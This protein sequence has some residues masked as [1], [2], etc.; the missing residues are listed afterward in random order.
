MLQPQRLWKMNRTP[1][2]PATHRPLEV[3]QCHWSVVRRRTRRNEAKHALYHEFLLDVYLSAGAA[4]RTEAA[5]NLIQQQQDGHDGINTPGDTQM[6]KAAE[7]LAKVSPLLRVWRLSVADFCDIVDEVETVVS[8][9][10]S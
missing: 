8:E 10:L 2:E 9:W 3:T 4:F 6:R 5:T 7:Y 1:T